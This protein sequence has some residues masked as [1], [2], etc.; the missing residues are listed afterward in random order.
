VLE[1]RFVLPT[2]QFFGQKSKLK[3]FFLQDFSL[4][5]SQKGEC[6]ANNSAVGP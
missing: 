5:E 6:S 1:A 2:G 4:R 3:K